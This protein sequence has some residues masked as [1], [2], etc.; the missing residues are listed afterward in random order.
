M[1]PARFGFPTRPS[2]HNDVNNFSTWAQAG[3][4]GE[5]KRSLDTARVIDVYSGR[6]DQN[7]TREWKNNVWQGQGVEEPTSKMS[8]VNHFRHSIAG[9]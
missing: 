3:R 5:G 6:F 8:V 9:I 2:D 4:T 1:P 7:M